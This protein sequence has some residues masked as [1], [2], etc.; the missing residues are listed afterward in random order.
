MALLREASQHVEGVDVVALDGLLVDGCRQLGAT[1][2]VRGVRSA[3]DLEYERQMALTNRAMDARIETVF[4]L[5]APEHQHVSSTLV[6]QIARMGGRRVGFRSTGCSKGHWRLVR[7]IRLMTAHQP[8]A[9]S[10]PRAPQA[11][12]PYSQA[13]V[14]DDV[15]Y[16]SGQIALDPQSGEMVGSNVA[17]E[18]EQVLKNLAAVLEQAGASFATVVKCTVYLASM[19]DFAA[20][21]D[22]YARHFGGTAPARSTVEV[23]RLPKDARVEIDCIARVVGSR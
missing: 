22:V 17:E 6:R 7:S 8:C 18:A 14:T 15:V 5:P 20:V 2:I 10:T 13:I 4:L 9:V 21:N 1:V 16:T 11:I 23:A 12:G 3:A 19:D